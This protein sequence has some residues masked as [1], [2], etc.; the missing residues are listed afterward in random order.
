MPLPIPVVF[1]FSG[2]PVS[3]G[4]AES[5][6]RP[7]QNLTGLT[8]MAAE[9][10]EKRLEILRDIV[11]GLSHVGLLANPEHPGEQLERDYA[12]S[13]AQKLNLAVSYFPTRSADELVAAFS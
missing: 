1:V 5:L 8:F 13:I 12:Q 4:L 7:R 2:D 10:N 11:P 6:A 3:A 9:M